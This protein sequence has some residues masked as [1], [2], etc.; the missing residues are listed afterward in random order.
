MSTTEQ[1]PSTPSVSLESPPVI[2]RQRRFGITI[3]KRRSAAVEQEPNLT[4]AQP[5]PIVR[6]ARSRKTVWIGIIVCAALTISVA[7]PVALNMR[8]PQPAFSSQ[9]IRYLGVYERGAPVS[10]A[11]VNAFTAATGVRPD[12]VMYYS[13]WQ[14]PFQVSFAINA[15]ENEAVHWCK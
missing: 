2:T 6:P 10:Y 15:A 1:A 7:I 8:S 12:V 4:P 14:E 9:S 5:T 3:T 13:S 11:G